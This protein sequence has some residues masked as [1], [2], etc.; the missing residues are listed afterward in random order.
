[1]KLNGI[2]P[3]IATYE[4]LL[5]TCGD[6]GLWQVNGSI[7]CG[8]NETNHLLQI[9]FFRWLLNCSET[10]KATATQPLQLLLPNATLKR[11]APVMLQIST[12]CASVFAKKCGVWG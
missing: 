9:M 1:M 6:A 4:R 8:E 12:R 2:F 3:N 7:K 5:A 10:Y 11:C